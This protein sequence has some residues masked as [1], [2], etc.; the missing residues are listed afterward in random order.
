M[1]ARQNLLVELLCEELPPK[2]LKQ[3]GDA[4][5]EGVFVGLKKRHYLETSSNSINYATPRRLAIW[6]SNVASVSP[7]TE[8]NEKL[9]LASIAFDTQ[10]RATAALK[11]RLEKF[12]RAHLADAWPNGVDGP[13]RLSITNDGK[14]DMAYLHMLSAGQPLQRGLHEAIEEA[15][16]GIPIAKVMTYQLEDGWTSVDFVRPARGLVA[17]H[18]S[19]IVS[20]HSLGFEAGRITSGHRFQ[21][22]K[23]IKLATANEYQA[24]METRGN[25]IPSFEKRRAEIDSQ[26]RAKAV[27]QN[28]ELETGDAYV[29]LLD[30]VT[31][32]VEFPT[33]YVG[34]FEPAFLEVPQECLILTMRAN[35]KY[36]PLLDRAGKLTNEFLI[37]SNMRLADPANIINGNERVIRPRLA[38]AKFFY[39]QDRKQSLEARLPKLADVVYHNKLGSQGERAE[40]V[41]AIARSVATLIGA[42]VEESVR[43]ARLAKADLVSDMVGEFPEL[44]GVIGR[45]YALH[46]G[47]TSAVADAI[48]D[49]YKPRFAGDSLPRGNVGC[50]LSLADKLETLTGLFGIGQTPTGDKDPFALRRHALGIVRI[51]IEQDIAVSL[52]DLL[53]AAAA[54]F[55]GKIGDANAELETF[56]FQR[57]DGYLRDQGYTANEVDSVLSQRPMMLHLVPRQLAAV[58]AFMLMPEAESLAAANKRVANILKKTEQNGKTVDR[59]KLI[60]PAERDLFAALHSAT[61]IASSRFAEKDF[62][63]YLKS[64]AMLKAPVD[65][66]FDSVMVMA[67]DAD[68]RNNRLALLQ[69]LRGAMNKVADISKLAA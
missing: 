30:E 67:D 20:V 69:D 48:E 41:T 23:I 55:E 60:E 58:R 62:A 68:L 3:L 45:Y 44:Q 17:L 39:D 37:V 6:I 5:G 49:H 63:G 25:V 57:L 2:S 51:V 64:F 65:A 53:Q 13:E 10:N 8:V 14:V 18:G 9:M 32:L 4:F 56:I 33:V 19:D 35:Q 15:I 54:A 22:E 1:T 34:Q 12:G 52:R 43:A 50:A 31:A 11:K 42:P 27:A 29:A 26:L 36:F 40:R 61:P 38:D 21:G 47:E 46:D 7:D 16:W 24:Q 66:F 59:E 28:A